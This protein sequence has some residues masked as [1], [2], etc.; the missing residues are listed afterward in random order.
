MRL[1]PLV[2]RS[3]HPSFLRGR[4]IPHPP[5][6]RQESRPPSCSAPSPSFPPRNNNK[7]RDRKTICTKTKQARRWRRVRRART[8]WGR[9]LESC[10][11]HPILGA[12]TL[13]QRVYLLSQDVR[14]IVDCFIFSKCT[15]AASGWRKRRK[16][17]Y[18]TSGTTAT[19]PISK[20]MLSFPPLQIPLISGPTTHLSNPTWTGDPQPACP[21]SVRDSASMIPFIL[22]G[23]PRLEQRATD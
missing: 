16:E 17:P 15:G 23:D 2:R 22:M 12:D 13:F 7:C 11:G 4:R 10:P 1:L 14:S 5:E 8:S 6:C 20:S 21:S 18:Q 3:L 19:S 9:R